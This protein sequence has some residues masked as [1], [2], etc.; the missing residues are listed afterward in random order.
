[1][2]LRILQQR[3]GRFRLHAREE[4]IIVAENVVSVC[5]LALFAAVTL[6]SIVQVNRF[7]AVSRLQLLAQAVAQQKVDQI[8]TTP[9][10]TSRP[11]VLTAGTQTE[12]GLQL[13]D[14]ALVSATDG[15]KSAYSDLDTAIP[16]KRITKITDLT[17]RT[18]RADITVTFTFRGKD[19]AV[20]MTTL[21]ASDRM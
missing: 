10:N 9:W 15:T 18:V 21:R 1:V 16:I 12:T 19:Y 11:A 2:L 8:L 3:L 4:G 14:N 5:L 7:A 17:A 6:T 13:N 20:Q